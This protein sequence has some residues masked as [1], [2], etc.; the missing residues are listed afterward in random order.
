V[1]LFILLT[2]GSVVVLC[3]MA[4][5][6]AARASRD[7]TLASQVLEAQMEQ[8]RAR[9]FSALHNGTTPLPPKSLAGLRQARGQVTIRDYPVEGVKHIT[10]EVHWQPPGG[11]WR[12]ARLD[13]LRRNVGTGAQEQSKA[14]LIPGPSQPSPHAGRARVGARDEEALWSQGLQPP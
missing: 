9:P 6:Q 3:L 10:V 8:L 4:G 11:P 1:A 14:A 5:V 2:A 13:T 7:L 12:S